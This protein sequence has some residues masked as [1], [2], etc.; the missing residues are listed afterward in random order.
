MRGFGCALFYGMDVFVMSFRKNILVIVL[1]YFVLF[2]LVGIGILLMRNMDLLEEP[3]TS[4]AAAESP[5]TVWIPETGEK[6]H[7]RPKCG[8][9]KKPTGTSRQEAERQGYGPCKT[10]YE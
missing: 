1:L 4:S 10:C 9:M 3:V 2:A 6:Y 5:E 7:R 8:N